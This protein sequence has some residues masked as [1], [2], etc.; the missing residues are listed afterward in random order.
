[1]SILTLLLYALILSVDA[2]TVAITD[3]MCHVGVARRRLWVAS[4][5][6]G[7]FQGIMPLIGYWAYFFLQERAAWFADAGRYIAFTLLLLLGA[8][9]IYDGIKAIHDRKLLECP[10]TLKPLR[11]RKILLQALATSV[12]ALAVGLSLCVSNLSATGSGT[13]TNIFFAASVIALVTFILSAAGAHAG[14]KLG[15][16]M[17]RYAPLVGGLV[18]IFLA[19]KILS[20]I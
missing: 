14:V 13:T 8:K 19:I 6:F 7:L 4:A 20:G 10:V 18:L 9:M 12:D 5:L 1:M 2:T 3:G 15:V 17:E 11:Y 16:F